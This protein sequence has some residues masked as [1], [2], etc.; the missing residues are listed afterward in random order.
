[1]NTGEVVS[2]TVEGHCDGKYALA[3]SVI[4]VVVV[5]VVATRSNKENM[6]K[7]LISLGLTQPK[8]RV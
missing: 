4:V 8:G 3:Y 1:M 7:L 2:P 6:Y 5:A